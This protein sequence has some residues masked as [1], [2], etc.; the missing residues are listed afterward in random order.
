MQG[1]Q[2]SVVTAVLVAWC[3]T[4][5]AGQKPRADSFDY[6]EPVFHRNTVIAERVQKAVILFG[7]TGLYRTDFDLT[8]PGASFIKLHFGQFRLPEGVTLEISNPDKSEVWRYSEKERDA[9]TVD[10]ALGDDGKSSFSAMSITGDSLRVR[11]VGK[12]FLLDPARHAIHV[13]SYL[14][15]LPLGMSKDVDSGLRD[16]GSPENEC[17]DDERY[18]AACWASSNPWEYNRSAAVAKLITSRGEVCSAWRVGSGNHLFTANHCLGKQSELD[19]AEIWFNYEATACGSSQNTAAVKVAGGSLLSNSQSLDYALFTVSDFSSV[20]SFPYFGLE[21]G[22]A[23]LGEEIFIPQHGLGRPRQIALESDMN[24]SGLCEVDALGLD[25]Y[26]T[27]S[28]I[29]YYCDTTTSSSGSPVVSNIT[30]RVL[31]IHHFGGCMNAGVQ[32]SKIWPQV[33]GIFG[34]T[35]PSG[36]SG[37]GG[38]GTGNQAP[39]ASFSFA[40]DELACSFDGSSSNDPDGEID[41]FSWSLGDGETASGTQVNYEYAAAGTYDITLTVEDDD[42]KSASTTQSVEVTIMNDEPRANFSAACVAT[43]CE[44]NGAASTDSDGEIVAWS[45]ILND[46]TYD[47]GQSITHDYAEAGSYTISLTVEDDLGGTDV[48]LKTINLSEPNE[49]PT[50]E[51]S[52]SC[53]ELNCIFDGS[54]SSDSDGEVLNWNWTLGDGSTASGQQVNH[55][56]TANGNYSVTLSVSDDKGATS[57]RTRTI[58]VSETPENED[59]VA[60]FSFSCSERD[61]NFDA[62]SSSDMDGDVTAWNWNFGDGGSATGQQVSHGFDSDGTFSVTVTVTD[63]DGANDSRSRSVAVSQTEEEPNQAPFAEF[64]FSCNDAVCTFD[65]GASYDPDGDSVSWAWSLGDGS[66]ASGEKVSH[67]FSST[68]S[69]SVTLTVEDGN[70]SKDTRIKKVT[71]TAQSDNEAPWAEFDYECSELTC[72]FDAGPSRDPD[73]NLVNYQWSMGD[74]STQDSMTV[75]HQFADAGRYRVTL[76]VQDDKGG[77]NSRTSTIEVERD[78]PIIALNGTGSRNNGRTLATLRW[79]GAETQTVQLFRD[80][81]LIA[82]TSNDGKHLDMGIDELAKSAGYRLCETAS[83]N[84]SNAIVLRFTPRSGQ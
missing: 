11:L 71:V 81:V 9:F 17:G 45:W 5:V 50:A 23:G 27:G 40:C 10:A 46:G 34:G 22:S 28:D 62:R 37:G 4:S 66:S 75:E 80:G 20:S 48:K 65:A 59:P 72:E 56:F 1:L 19:G 38:G 7:A 32:I 74:G 39:A 35:V 12:L 24:D 3:V 76:T 57:G 77:T 82:T 43:H 36:G 70:G 52:F 16:F 79:S 73:G 44:F 29:G 42:G 15:G 14:E 33:S 30:G 31:A 2:R 83:A 67:E 13:D 21:V 53:T 61:C 63:N 78:R 55:A 6:S 51:F 68:G 69:Y 60:N 18:D 84:C 54:P 49:K 8:V 25:G 58:N 47:S 41:D 26:A 64:S